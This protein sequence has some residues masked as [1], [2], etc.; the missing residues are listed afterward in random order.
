MLNFGTRKWSPEGWGGPKF[1]G[2]AAG[3]SHDSPRA[4]TCTFQD[5]GLQKHQQN[6]T[7]G[8]QERERRLKIVEEGKKSEILGGPAE[9]CPAEG[10]AQRKGPSANG[11]QGSG[12]GFS[13]GFWGRKQKQNKNKMKRD[14]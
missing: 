13:S 11:V 10:G 5:S 7:K 2:G 9:G 14:E 4:Q 3:V 1:P 12:F 8:L 6:S